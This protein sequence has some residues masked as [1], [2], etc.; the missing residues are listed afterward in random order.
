MMAI[1][2]IVMVIFCV[3]GGYIIFGGKIGIIVEAMPKELMIIGG[4]AAGAFMIGQ[5]SHGLKHALS[6]VKKIVGGSKFH[7]E[8][9]IQL[10]TL[11]YSM[12]KLMKQKGSIA[13]EAHIENPGESTLFQKAPLIQQ[14]KFGL[15][16]IC[17]YMR[18]ITLGLTSPHEVESIIEKELAKYKE[19]EMHPSH[20]WQ[21]MADGMPALGIVAAVL[22][23][24]K[25][26]GSITEPPEVL[27]QLIGGALVGTFLGVFLAYGFVGPIASR[28]KGVVDEEMRFYETIMSIMIAHL[29]GY[30]PAVSAETGRKSVPSEYMPT[31]NELEEALNQA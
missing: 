28:L 17:D 12:T 6:A 7:K 14:D 30:A 16:L 9:Y 13:V 5:S 27:G 3:L 1:A 20:A 10:I 8:H 29:N 23:V 31:F 21:S 22:G 18:M 26:M 19:E 4:S 2:G 24:I 25:T 11:M 15:S